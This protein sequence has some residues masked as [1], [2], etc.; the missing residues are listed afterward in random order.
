MPKTPIANS[1]NK[2]EECNFDLQKERDH[3]KATLKREFALGQILGKSKAIKILKESLDKISS[4]DVNVLITGESGTGKELVARALHYLSNRKGKPFIPV[5]CGAI[6]EN[7][8]ENE[9]FGHLKGAYT[10][11]SVQQIGLGKE[12]RKVIPCFLMR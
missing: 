11:A 12:K 7:L 2:W 1:V 5:N 4:C 8:F 6:P 10:D 9:L 3:V